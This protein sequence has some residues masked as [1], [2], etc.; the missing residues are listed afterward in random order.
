MTD[1]RLQILNFYLVIIEGEYV[2]RSRQQ[3]LTMSGSVYAHVSQIGMHAGDSL[4][5][6]LHT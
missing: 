4:A 3:I 1:F 6:I 5:I 2:L